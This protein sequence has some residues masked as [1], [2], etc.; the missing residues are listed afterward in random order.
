MKCALATIFFFLA[1]G[2]ACA[3][4]A[5]VFSPNGQYLGTAIKNGNM[6]VFV[7]KNGKY[8]G[9]VVQSH[10]GMTIID[11]NGQHSILPPHWSAR[12]THGYGHN[13]SNY[14]PRPPYP[15]AGYGHRPPHY[16]PGYGHRPL[17]GYNN[18]FG[19]AYR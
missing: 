5:P 17:N 9:S 7:D 4:S 15:Y 12:P 11:K 3:Q 6:T 2:S 14:A 8:G 16:H 10:N 13:A 18:G 1:A 19:G